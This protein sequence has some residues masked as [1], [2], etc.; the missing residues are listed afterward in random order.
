MYITFIELIVLY[1]DTVSTFK[2]AFSFSIS[3]AEVYLKDIFQIIVYNNKCCWQGYYTLFALF[4]NWF[5]KCKAVKLLMYPSVPSYSYK[6]TT[7]ENKKLR[8]P[9]V[10]ESNPSL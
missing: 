5:S 7:V 9:K 2:S 6:Q 1:S 8:R 4:A 10:S 3:Q